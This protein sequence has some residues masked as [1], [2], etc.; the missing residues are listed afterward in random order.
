MLIK[1]INCERIKCKNTLIWPAFFLIPIIPTVMGAGNYLNNIGILKSEWYSLW[2]QISLFYSNFFFPPLIGVYCAFLWRFENFHSCRH[3]L[4]TQPVKLSTIYCSKYCM[5]CAIT[6]LTQLW[7]TDLYL[8]SGKI[9]GL[10]GLPPTD[11]CGWIVRGTIGGFVI[12]TVQ[13][14]VASVIRNFAIPIA[15]GLFGGISGLLISNTSA[16]IY[17][18]YS[19]MLLGM[20]SNK[21]D[22]MLSSQLPLFFFFSIFY[23]LLF[24]LLGIWMLGKNES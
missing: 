14:L 4:M 13:Y 20:N 8:V 12:A 19:L 3:T 24:L 16:G 6:V 2:T 23:I 1:A 18:P 10:P 21:Y 11:I 5:V 9:V 15:V 7:F 22:D 17:W